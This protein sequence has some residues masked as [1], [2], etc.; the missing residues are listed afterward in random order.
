MEMVAEA[1][2]HGN[3]KRLIKLLLVVPWLLRPC[4][5]LS[6]IQSDSLLQNGAL[7]DC[8]EYALS[9]QP[10]IRQSRLDEEITDHAISGKMAD[11]YPQLSFNAY[12]QHNPQLPISIVQGNIAK[13]GMANASS[14]QFS[15]TQ[16]IFNRNVLLASST[17]ADERNQARQTT[18]R[19]EIDVVIAVSKAYYAALVTQQQIGI[20]DEDI[21]RLELS[22]KDAFAQYQ[23]GIVDKTDY[24]RATIS[25]NNIRAER[26]Q[27]QELLKARFASLKEQMGYPSHADLV[28]E[29]DST[30]MEREA[31]IDTTQTVSVES[32]VEYQL[33]M[34]QKRLQ[35]ANL[36]YAR[37]SFLPSL[38]AFGNYNL[39]YQSGELSQLFQRNYPNSNVGLQLS[40]PIFQGGK[41]IQEI[42][43]AQLELER[44]KY[45]AIALRNSVNTQYTQALAN[46]RS[47]LNNYHVLQENLELA[48]EVYH[49]IQQQY[50]AG[51]KT[52]LEVIA[53]E[54]DLRSAQDNHIDA[55]YQV[56]TSKLDVQKAL[57][58]VHY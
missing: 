44:V 30:Q 37:W 7:R 13:V 4:G 42:K 18:V 48:R 58:T 28:L 1:P 52:Y 36:D 27:A 8:V 47:S 21:V 55:L 17:A 53:A 31:F 57:G 15:L 11:W 43:Q 20:L 16:T 39:N 25:L 22:L 5:S 33:L 12:I 19:N 14:G 34:T 41:R 6:Q 40:F 9:H 2:K 56:L 35:E 23:G 38:T 3:M 49:T 51:V 54:T 50:K 26:L 46:Y 32:R 24:K 45:D 29:S 10:S